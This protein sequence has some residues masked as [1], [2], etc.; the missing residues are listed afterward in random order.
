MISCFALLAPSRP[1]RKHHVALFALCCSLYIDHLPING[2]YA[3]LHLPIG[4][5]TRK[6]AIPIHR[7]WDL[8]HWLID[9]L[10]IT[11]QLCIKELEIE[12]YFSTLPDS[13]SQIICLAYWY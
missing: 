9:L 2:R 11:W 1:Y 12:L 13:K 5:Y 3:P 4:S 8:F 6:V 10:G 7:I